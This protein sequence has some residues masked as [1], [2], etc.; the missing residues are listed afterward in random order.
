MLVWGE[1]AT[2]LVVGVSPVPM[3]FLEEVLEALEC[4]FT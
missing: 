1:R 2:F 3:L 4:V